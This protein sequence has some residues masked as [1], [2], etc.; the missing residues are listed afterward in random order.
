MGASTSAPKTGACIGGGATGCAETELNSGGCESA[1]TGGCDGGGTTGFSVIGAVSNGGCIGGD[2]MWHLSASRSFNGDQDGG[3]TIEEGRRTSVAKIGACCGGE[4]CGDF[5]VQLRTGGCSGG[6]GGNTGAR[7]ACNKS[8]FSISASRALRLLSLGLPLLETG[9]SNAISAAEE[10]TT[11]AKLSSSSSP[12]VFS[13]DSS[14]PRLRSSK[15]GGGQIPKTDA[16]SSFVYLSRG[17]CC[18]N[19]GKLKLGKASLYCCG[20]SSPRGPNGSAG[21]QSGDVAILGRSLPG[22]LPMEVLREQDRLAPLSASIGSS[23]LLPTTA[24]ARFETT[25]LAIMPESRRS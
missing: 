23:K 15:P 12:S 17:E 10:A 18:P 14:V 9:V 8:K 4:N 11:Q 5:L 13:L 25:G 16:L 19:A 6:G 24:E 2:T 22:E 7:G 20:L 21:E 3:G 1:N